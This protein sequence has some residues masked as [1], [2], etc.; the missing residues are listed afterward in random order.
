MIH[1]L[2]NRIKANSSYLLTYQ[3]RDD[4]SRDMFPSGQWQVGFESASRDFRV[5]FYETKEIHEHLL[6]VVIYNEHIED[7]AIE[8]LAIHIEN[9]QWQIIKKVDIAIFESYNLT[10]DGRNQHDERAEK[11]RKRS[12]E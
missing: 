11:M 3:E 6:I 9:I 10:I 5:P 4:I 7:D 8:W 2:Q 12:A 1:L